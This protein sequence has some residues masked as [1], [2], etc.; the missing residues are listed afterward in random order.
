MATKDIKSKEKKERV[1]GWKE[2]LKLAFQQNKDINPEDLSE[3]ERKYWQKLQTSDVKK[4]SKV[5]LLDKAK[6]LKEKIIAN[7][8][9]LAD[10]I[11]NK[12]MAKE[13]Q[14][15]AWETRKEELKAE[16]AKKRK[17][18]ALKKRE[19]KAKKLSQ[20]HSSIPTKDTSEKQKT[21]DKVIEEKH[22]EKMIAKE[23]KFKDFNSKRQ[24]L[25]K[26]ERIERNKKRAIKLIHHKEVKDKIKHTTAEERE[27]NAAENRRIAYQNYLAEMQ[28]QQS[29]KE[30]DPKA[31][32]ERKEKRSTAKKDRMQML[33][34]KRLKRMERLQIVKLT[35]KQKL[36]KDL[37]HFKQAQEARNAKKKEQRAKYLTKGGKKVPKVKNKVDV[38]P[39]IVEEKVDNK[40]R[41]LTRTQYIG[42]NT[43]DGE[44][45]GA[46]T[47]IPTKLKDIVKYNFNKL[48]EKESD[49]LV[50]IFIYNSDNP[51]V[52]VMEMVNSKY[53]EIDGVTTTRMNQEKQR[54]A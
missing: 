38:R 54:A 1:L 43:P 16:A 15:K 52:C 47:C 12:A 19:E 6:S 49:N 34:E 20:I 8:N 3:K 44:T 48:M 45:V 14:E 26:E 27:A 21:I 40:H 35:Q 4:K 13:E 39:T 50:G 9:I 46:I 29:E 36:A 31:A 53:R 17:E 32:A 37:E 41:Y 11:L 25:T 30:A 7:A 42:K 28:R 22:D 24:K 51:E 33:A 2:N 18:A 5:T 23:T 10:K